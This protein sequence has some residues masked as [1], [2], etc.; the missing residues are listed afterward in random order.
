MEGNACY[1]FKTNADYTSISE[2]SLGARTSV[3]SEFQ[4]TFETD[5]FIAYQVITPESNYY[6]VFGQYK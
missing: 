3:S 6:L 2:E 4:F 5:S 1:F